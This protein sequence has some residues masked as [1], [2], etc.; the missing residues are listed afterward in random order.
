MLRFLDSLFFFLPQ[1]KWKSLFTQAHLDSLKTL[2]SKRKISFSLLTSFGSKL[3]P[4]NGGPAYTLTGHCSTIRKC[5]CRVLVGGPTKNMGAI[6]LQYISAGVF[7]KIRFA[8]VV[9][10]V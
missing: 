5:P 10:T 3:L 2:V 1:V 8:Y 4:T 7:H 6:E 9:Q